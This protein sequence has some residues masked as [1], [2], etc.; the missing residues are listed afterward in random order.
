MVLFEVLFVTTCLTVGLLWTC[1]DS[2]DLLY[3]PVSV[4]SVAEFFL[5]VLGPFSVALGLF[6]FKK[7]QKCWGLHIDILEPAGSLWKLCKDCCSAALTYIYQKPFHGSKYPKGR[8]PCGLQWSFSASS[9][10]EAVITQRDPVAVGW[11]FQFVE[12]GQ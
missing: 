7:K 10:V 4:F 3:K 2:G 9:G 6:L 1:H 5:V 8:Y 12:K 11:L